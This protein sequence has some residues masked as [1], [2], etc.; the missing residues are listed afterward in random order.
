MFS[1]L[2]TGTTNGVVKQIAGNWNGLQV[3]PNTLSNGVYAVSWATPF[4]TT[5]YIVQLTTEGSPG[6]DAVY[7]TEK[8]VNGFTLQSTN[9][10]GAK[11]NIL[12]NVAI[13][14]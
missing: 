2:D 13:F 14:N 4:P 6:N 10:A 12:I 9:T 11:I 5:N 3:T 8:T 7:I 1:V